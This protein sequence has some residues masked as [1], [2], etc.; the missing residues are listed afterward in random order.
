MRP[1]AVAMAD[2][3]ENE[4]S[5]T[6]LT[7]A[8]DTNSIWKIVAI[9]LGTLAG[10]WM[11]GQARSLVG[12]LFFSF[13][14]SL[15]LQP[16]VLHLVHRFGWRR[17]SAVGVIYVSGIVALIAF[18]F[19]IVPAIVRL[20]D[21]I[22]ANGQ[23]WLQD[24]AQWLEDTFGI[25]VGDRSGGGGISQDAAVALEDWAKGAVGNI[26]GLAAA[27]IG[28]VFNLATI[29]MFTFYF[30]ADA[31]R[32]QRTILGLLPPHLQQR[33][34]WTW[35]QAVVQ[36]GGYFYSRII[37]M[38][39]NGIGFFFTMVLVGFPPFIALALAL[40]SSFIAEFIPAIGTYI[41]SAIP[42]LFSFGF[43]GWIGAVILLAYALIY[44][45]IENYILSPRISS[46]TMSLNGAVAFGAALAGGAIF[47]PIGAFVALPVAA[48]ITSLISNFA[49]H[50][51][52]VY[53]FEYDKVVE[54]SNKAI[55][56]QKKRIAEIDGVSR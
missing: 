23:Q 40:I 55:K 30:T 34:G 47:G 21:S 11:I 35:D 14:M 53:E 2:S 52:V 54:A 49:T 25:T 45:Q 48:L 1:Y 17:G 56:R 19:V 41:G 33:I 42:I 29:A 50:N 37:L 36:T 6:R 46:N 27:G 22:A 15:A 20:A 39:I 4:D 16:L 38:I 7:I 24:G 51:D 13:F 28:L 31:P 10:L 18:A 3:R 12:M 32:L 43:S 9:V 26:L 5:P 8:I 44:Q